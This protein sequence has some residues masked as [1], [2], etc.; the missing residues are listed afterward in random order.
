[1]EYRHAD[2]ANFDSELAIQSRI[3]DAMFTDGGGSGT[4]G[5]GNGDE[6]SGRVP[7]MEPPRRR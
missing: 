7:V 2:T 1:M 3:A 4:N 6:P 5:S